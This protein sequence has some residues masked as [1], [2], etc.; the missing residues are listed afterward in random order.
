M[1]WDGQV[2]LWGFKRQFTHESGHALMC[3]LRQISCHGIAYDKSEPRFC[4]LR[5]L[6]EQGSSLTESDRL[7]F[8]AGVAAEQ[9]APSFDT[10][11]WQDGAE[12]DKK[13]F[14]DEHSFDEAV[15]TAREILLRNKPTIEALCLVLMKKAKEFHGRVEYL[16][17]C[18]I[19]SHDY[20]IL[21]SAGE[22]A[23]VIG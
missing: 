4:T 18:T 6:P 5:A 12:S 15:K 20:A 14:P 11:D 17:E 19:N 8:A 22:L 13:Y 7:I 1:N 21:L 23:A 9:I 10:S 16:P 2:L 3:H